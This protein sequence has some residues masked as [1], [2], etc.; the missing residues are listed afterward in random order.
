LSIEVDRHIYNV[1]PVLGNQQ[2]FSL[3]PTTL[4][5]RTI[6]DLTFSLEERSPYS[7][8]LANTSFLFIL[9]QNSNMAPYQ[10]KHADNNDEESTVV[11]ALSTGT[12]SLT[13][14]KRKLRFSLESNQ[15]FPIPHIDDMDDE[16]VN[17]IWWD[18]EFYDATK[19]EI[20]L[21]VRKMRKGEKIED[22]NNQTSRG[23]EHLTH[24]AEN[25]R[26]AVKVVMKEQKRQR[27]EGVQ[28]DERLA[29]VYR[30]VS[31]HLQD[32]AYS[33]G[34]KDE[35]GLKKELE[36]MRAKPKA[37]GINSLLKKFRLHRRPV[38]EVIGP[39]KTRVMGQAV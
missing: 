37:R 11:T 6:L 38:P 12:S 1:V 16:E 33:L 24:L 36:Q 23:L 3:L 9:L 19:S 13:R 28:S 10:K 29:E 17:A 22:N 31:S 39:D 18:E 21:I 35:A 25:R 30:N 4:F 14:P 34:L 5:F 26:V 2:L 8:L 20:I 27:D 7:L 32:A 15:S